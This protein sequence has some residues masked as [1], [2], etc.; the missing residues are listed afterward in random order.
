MGVSTYHKQPRVHP[1][2]FLSLTDIM[3]IK[4]LGGSSS[5]VVISASKLYEYMSNGLR[6][7]LVKSNSSSSRSYS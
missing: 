2:V 7:Q 4:V 3:I 6:A 5:T 1:S